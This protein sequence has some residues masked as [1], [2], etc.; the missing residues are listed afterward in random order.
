[1]VNQVVSIARFVRHLR[2]GSQPLL[3]E[4]TDGN[5]YVLKF[6]NNLQG[7]HV[8]F[9]ESMGTEL[10]RAC[11]L[12]VPGWSPIYVDAQFIDD[13]RE[14]WLQAERGSI[15]P[16]S[17]WSFGSRFVQVPGTHL[18]DLLS[19]NDFK[20]VRNLDS[21][22]LSWLIDVCANHSDNRQ[23]LFVEHV[24]REF[25]A[26]FIDHGHLF[27][28]A[29]GG[30]QPHPRVSR[31]LDGRVYAAIPEFS[32]ERIEKTLKNLD[33]DALFK[34]AVELPADWITEM[35]RKA[36]ESCL[37]RLKNPTLWQNVLH[38]LLISCE[39]TCRYGSFPI[40]AASA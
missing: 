32:I 4:G 40:P 3:V 1:L 14:C 9:N 26:Y 8:L 28:G 33:A 27:G 2:G 10:Y 25:E 39:G 35:D 15:R 34:R 29:K 30:E 11:G 7:S 24:S 22:W 19:G 38:E 20:R 18:R 6:Q 17:G 37:D 16:L 36:L 23:A 13:H 31:Y 12:Q 21:F 5:L